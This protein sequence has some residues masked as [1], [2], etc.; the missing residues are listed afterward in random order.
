MKA[1][2]FTL[3]MA[4]STIG[5]AITPPHHPVQAY[6]HSP[7]YYVL[8]NHDPYNAYRCWV[9]FPDGYTLQFVIYPNFVTS[10]FPMQSDFGCY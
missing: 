1:L 4:F 7:G 9:V 8:R 2:L 6:M 5:Y 3:L 10:P